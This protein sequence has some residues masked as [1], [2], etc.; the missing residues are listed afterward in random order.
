[1]E[2]PVNIDEYIASFTPATQNKLEQIRSIIRKAAPGA[3]EVISY[4]M[5]ACKF[6]GLLVWYA[7]HKAHIGFYP[8]A[9]GIETFKQ[10]LSGYKTAKGSVQ[11]P[12]DQPLPAKLISEIVKFRAI[13]N[14]QKQ[15]A[16]K[17]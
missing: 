5:P 16:K 13:E 11:F 10:E 15:A 8:K 1:M 9:S 7:A 2:K 12:L 14:L 4:S 17:K 6:N 3:V